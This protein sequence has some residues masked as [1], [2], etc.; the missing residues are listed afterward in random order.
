MAADGIRIKKIL[1]RL[2]NL[3]Q[4][5]ILETHRK[6]SVHLFPP[7]PLSDFKDPTREEVKGTVPWGSKRGLGILWGVDEQRSQQLSLI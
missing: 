4:M 2:A 6:R 3:N 5:Q 1:N 7:L